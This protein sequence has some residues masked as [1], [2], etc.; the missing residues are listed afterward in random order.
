MAMRRRMASLAVWNFSAKGCDSAGEIVNK[1]APVCARIGIEMHRIRFAEVAA[2]AQA[3]I[4]G[5]SQN[6]G[7]GW[8]VHVTPFGDVHASSCRMKAVLSGGDSGGIFPNGIL[9]C[10]ISVARRELQRDALCSGP[11]NKI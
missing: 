5:C 3:G 9:L 4:F 11:L 8:S 6:S 7:V 2:P 10:L 1:L